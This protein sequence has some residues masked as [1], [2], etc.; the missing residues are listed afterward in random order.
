MNI[1]TSTN[2]T[3]QIQHSDQT[4]NHLLYNK[5]KKKIVFVNIVTIM[6][7]VTNINKEQKKKK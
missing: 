5:I 1:E 7:I 3:P 4:Q 6:A 2:P